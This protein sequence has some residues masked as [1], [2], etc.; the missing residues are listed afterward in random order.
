MSY[1]WLFD[2]WHSIVTLTLSWHMGNVGSAQPLVDVNKFEK[3]NFKWFRIYRADTIMETDG[4][5]DGRTRQSESIKA[6]PPA[7]FCG[8]SKISDWEIE[9]WI[10][11]A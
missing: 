5:T 10:R 9:A 6:P 4:R 8:G 1:I 7:L 3:K 2:I 11:L